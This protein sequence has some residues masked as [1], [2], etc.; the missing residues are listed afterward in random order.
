MASMVYA[1]KMIKE[2]GLA[3]D[4]TVLMVGSVQEEDC[5][6]LCWQYIINES[7]I[8]PD[9]SSALSRLTAEFTAGIEDAWRLK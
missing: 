5:D 2:M 7:K 6:G 4:C 1:G 8:R 9:L 3:K